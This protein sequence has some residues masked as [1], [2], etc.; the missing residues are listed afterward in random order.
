MFL[1]A[2]Y[3]KIQVFWSGRWCRLVKNYRRN[4]RSAIVCQSTQCNIPEELCFL[5][6]FP[7]VGEDKAVCLIAK[8]LLILTLFRKWLL[9]LF[10]Q[11]RQ[12]SFRVK[13]W[14]L[15]D[16]SSITEI[17]NN[18]EQ[19]WSNIYLEKT[20]VK[21]RKTIPLLFCTTQI[22]HIHIASERT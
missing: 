22:S 17:I 13:P 5:N 14:L 19:F 7:C 8:M 15:R 9:F 2:M 20:E 18:M 10:S 12:Y 1:I 16:R 11:F 3:L 6:I 21:E 4:E